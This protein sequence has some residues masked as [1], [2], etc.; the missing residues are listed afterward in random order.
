M[1]LQDVAQII[2]ADNRAIANAMTFGHLAPKPITEYK[3][4]ILFTITSWGDLVPI[5]AE[6]KNLDMSPWLFEDI[7]EYI[8]KFW[9][10]HKDKSGSNR[11]YGKVFKVEGTYK[12][13]KNGNF[14]MSGKVKCIKS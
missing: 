12:K 6:F 8:H 14:R 10:K 2:E 13:F 9:K 3:G 7:K 4:F 11:I 5:E 1:G